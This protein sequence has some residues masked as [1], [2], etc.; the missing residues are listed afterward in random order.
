MQNEDTYVLNNKELLRIVQDLKGVHLW[1]DLVDDRLL[2]ALSREDG[3]AVKQASQTVE[4]GYCT[5]RRCK[6]KNLP[7]T[8]L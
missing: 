8:M 5:R 3:K 6:T 4:V 1:L 2:S 7:G